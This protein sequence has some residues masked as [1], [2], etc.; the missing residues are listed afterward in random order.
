MARREKRCTPW[1]VDPL[2]ASIV[3]SLCTAL[4]GYA[5]EEEEPSTAHT[6]RGAQPRRCTAQDRRSLS[7]DGVRG[8]LPEPAGETG[9]ARLRRSAS[10]HHLLYAPRRAVLGSTCRSP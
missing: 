7:R 6:G 4:G 9:Q 5:A 2:A 3:I 10:R 1:R 8:P